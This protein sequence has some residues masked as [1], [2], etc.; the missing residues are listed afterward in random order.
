MILRYLIF[1]LIGLFLYYLVR[2]LFKPS[3][4]KGKRGEEASEMVLDQQC[5]R[6]VL[7]KDAWRLKRNG[8]SLYF[9]SE[10]CLNGYREKGGN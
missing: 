9:C 10:K 1:I 8:D 2:R 3:K 5:G 7:Q 4:P 6:Y